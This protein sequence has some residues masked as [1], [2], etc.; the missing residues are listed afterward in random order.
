M[1]AL[2][3]R[4]D[5]LLPKYI[6]IVLDDDLITHLN[7]NEEDGTATLLGSWIEWLAKE[8]ESLLQE[9]WKQL[10]EKSKR[11]LPFIYW[12]NA[13]THSFFSKARNQL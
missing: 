3:S 9:R 1:N 6:V 8:L 7:F 12:V 13:P 5:G 2:N 4:K 10:P 11:L